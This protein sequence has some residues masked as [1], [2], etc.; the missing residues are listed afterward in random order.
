VKAALVH[1]HLRPGGV[2]QVVLHQALALR[3]AGEEALVISGEAPPLAESWAGIPIKVVPALRYDRYRAPAS[4]GHGSGGGNGSGGS[5]GESGNGAGQGETA[6][7]LAAAVEGAVASHWGP[8][9]A[10]VLVHVHNP[11]IRKNSLLTGALKILANTFPLLLQNHDLAEDFR[12]DVYSGED[13]P[14]NCHYAVINSRDYRFLLEAGLKAEGLHLLPNEVRRTEVTPGLPKT[15]YLYPVRGI[16][17]KNIGEVLLLSLYIN[18]ANGGGANSG[19]AGNGGGVTDGFRAAITQPPT[20]EQDLPVYR[21]WKTAAAE[22]GLPVE[23]EAGVGASF[24][25][26]MGSARAVITTSVKEGFGFSFL[27]PWIAG[28]GASGIAVTGRRIDYVCRDFEEAGAGFDSFYRTLDIPAEYAEPEKL[29]RKAARALEGVYAAFGLPLPPGV[30]AALEAAFSDRGAIDFGVMDEE[31]Q[32]RILRLAAA[33]RGVWKKIQRAN[34]FLEGLP[35]WQPCPRRIEQN[36]EAILAAYSREKITGLLLDIYRGVLSP[37]RQDISRRRL[38]DLYLDP[39][40]IFLTGI[41]PAPNGG[42]PNGGTL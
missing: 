13:Y 10:G 9:R 37:V 5:G 22:L 4:A 17:R 2:T 19:A 23:F 8:D 38:L 3:E 30:P 41:S 7:E 42:T 27:E 35:D 36:R 15:R 11:L 25:D 28:S 16:R 29:R 31:G 24:A 21:R 18:G 12:P 34:P 1:Y 6:G 33:D 20:T 26:I 40:R 14:A 39:S 32:E